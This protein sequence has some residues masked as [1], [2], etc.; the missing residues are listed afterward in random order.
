[1]I[2]ARLALLLAPLLVAAAAPEISADQLL[3]DAQALVARGEQAADSPEAAALR[4]QLIEAGRAARVRINA[5]LA[6]GKRANVCLPPPGTTQ[7]SLGDVVDG[8]SGLT[9]EERAQPLSEGM[10]IYL[11]RRFACAPK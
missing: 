7:L 2:R 3:A 4:D 8:L 1:M 6:S 10:A 11:A 9:T 5:D